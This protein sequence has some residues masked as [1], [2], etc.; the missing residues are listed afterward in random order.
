M[1][2]YGKA[3]RVDGKVDDVVQ[4]QQANPWMLTQ[5]LAQRWWMHPA[6]FGVEQAAAGQGDPGAGFGLLAAQRV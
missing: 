5:S 1:K 2:D 4:G 6:T 3:F